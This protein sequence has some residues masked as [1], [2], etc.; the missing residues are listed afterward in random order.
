MRQSLLPVGPRRHRENS[1]F[2]FS[3]FRR[4]RATRY[5]IFS[6]SGMFGGNLQSHV[7][8][9]LYCLFMEKEILLDKNFLPHR[10]P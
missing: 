3:V 2:F 10:A 4:L 7:S 6:Q 1:I 8:F 9:S 5:E